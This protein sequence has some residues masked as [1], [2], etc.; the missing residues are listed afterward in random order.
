MSV[1]RWRGMLSLCAAS[2]LSSTVGS[3]LRNDQCRGEWVRLITPLH[4]QNLYELALSYN[5]R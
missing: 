2:L 4:L 1:H 5:A 3:H